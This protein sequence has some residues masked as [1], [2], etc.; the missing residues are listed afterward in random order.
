MAVNTQVAYT[1]TASEIIRQAFRYINIIDVNEELANEQYREGFIILNNIVKQL[2]AVPN[3]VWPRTEIAV[4][5]LPYNKNAYALG[6]NG[7]P[8]TRLSDLRLPVLLST[9][10]STQLPVDSVYDISIG[11]NV[12]VP[13]IN[14][15]L[16]W[17]T[18]SAVDNVNNVITLSSTL[19]SSVNYQQRIF[20]YQ[21]QANKPL[22]IYSGRVDIGANSPNDLD[23]AMQEIGYTDYMNMGLKKMASIPT[24]YHYQPLLDSGTLYI[25]PTPQQV[26]YFM[27][28]TCAM[29]LADFINADDNPDFP[30]EWNRALTLALARDL[31][32][33][34][35]RNTEVYQRA[36]TLADEALKK[37]EVWDTDTSSIHFNYCDNQYY[38]H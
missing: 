9:I 35:S 31:A 34:Y 6:T 11:W 17:S 5:A 23:V 15:T 16:F 33:S 14:N 36:V 12:G 4:F 22:Q 1:Q 38:Q 10:M 25:F 18:V 21:N 20:C 7:V 30:D 13:L 2:Q 8:A 24:S 19:P 3:R 37:L 26:N 28:F 27:K 32:F 29:Q